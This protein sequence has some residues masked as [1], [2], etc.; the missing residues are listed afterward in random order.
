M[1][2][3]LWKETREDREEQVRKLLDSVLE[4]VSDAPVVAMQKKL[5]QH[6][7]TI[8][9]LKDEITSLREKRLRAPESSALPDLFSQTKSSID[10]KIADRQA[11]IVLN[12][13]AITKIKV[14]SRPRSP[15]P[16]SK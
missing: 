3:P 8:S 2:P 10:D 1:I 13:E 11:R 14:R 4:I 16:A 9:D 6:R 12:E 5:H 15:P 7:R